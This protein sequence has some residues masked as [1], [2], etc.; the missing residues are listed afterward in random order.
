MFM[1]WGKHRGQHVRDVPGGYLAWVL[2]ECDNVNWQ[3]RDAIRAELADRLGLQPA[4]PR[5]QPSPRPDYRPLADA[6]NKW[7][8]Q[9]CLQHH[10][11]R[12]G[13]E[14]VM[15]ALNDARDELARLLAG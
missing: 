3:L 14:R 1:P 7:H 12:G 5:Y 6:L 9:A 11:D 15:M 10:P 4:A 13:D 2:E 8:R